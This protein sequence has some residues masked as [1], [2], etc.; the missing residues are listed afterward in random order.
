MFRSCLRGLAVAV[1]VAF[2]L[3]L[4][5]TPSSAVQRTVTIYQIQDTTSVGHVNEG[6][7]DTITT[8]G[9]ITGADIRPTGFGYYIE[10]P[11]GG[12]YSGV[13]VFTGGTNAMA[14]SGYALGDVIQ[15]KGKI[16]GFQGGTEII[17]FQGGTGFGAPPQTS[18]I[19]TAAVPAPL[20]VT[21][22]GI[23]ELAAYTTAERFEGVLVALTGTGRT[24]RNTGVGVD[25]YLIVDSTLP[26]VPPMDSVR[27]DAFTLAY[28]EL[29]PPL[30]GV[31]VSNVKG[32][33]NQSTRGYHIELR[34]GADITQPSP[35]TLLNAWATNN[36]TIR[37]LFDRALDPGTANDAGNY[38]RA[39]LKAVDAAAIV[40]ASSQSVD[41]TTVVDPQVPGEA[42]EVTASGVKS[43][44]GDPM[45]AAAKQAF[46]AGITPITAVQTNFTVNPPFHPAPSDSSQ[47]TFQQ[48]TVRGVVTAKDN[49][50]YYMQDGTGTNPSSAVLVFAP[51]T[52]LHE[53]DDLTVSGVI[54]EFGAASQATEYSGLDYQ[55]TNA[56]GVALP[57]PVVTTP[58]AVGP[59]TGSEPFPGEAYE[60]MLIRMNNVVVYRDSLPN[61]QY[62]VG[63]LPSLGDTVRVDDNM[64]HYIYRAG[65][66][67]NITG[68]V[69]DA[70]GQYVV[71]PR[72]AADVESLTVVGVDPGGAALEFSLKSISPTPVSFSKGGAA[73]LRFNLPTAGKVSVRVYD[74]NGRLVAEPAN[75]VAFAAGSQSL[76]LDGRTRTGERMRSGIFFVQLKFGN[77]VAAG[78]F[79]VAE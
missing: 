33:A 77:R 60:G 18:K 13:Q 56:T 53:G 32:I 45:S 34:D 66:S 54:T 79:V 11:A 55:F 23:S 68:V 16:L 7:P 43:A 9:I 75:E 10:D 15:A 67:L 74:I 31:V 22:P 51:L 35:P 64:Y 17:G 58:G 27:V 1:P 50:T 29:A 42:E 5:A 71:L 3:A 8:S 24:A 63:S 70:F 57:A 36:N 76:A 59:L 14:D 52:G 26:S 73:L 78:K 39:T 69:N 61:G 48:V 6:S 2:L 40:G 37:L 25:Q 49:Q 30:L 46:R 62:K 47:F 4:H 38:S 12:F 65:T 21:F 72:R 44:L 19:G 28:P 41:L 20:A